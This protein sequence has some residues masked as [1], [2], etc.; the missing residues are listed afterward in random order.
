MGFGREAAL[1]FSGRLRTG[2]ILAPILL[3]GCTG[4]QSALSPAG[5]QAESLASLFWWMTFGTVVVWAGVIVLTVYAIRTEPDPIK[6]PRRAKLL[7]VVGGA[8]IPTIVLGVLLV[9]GLSLLPPMVAPAP[10]GSLRI[11]V[12]GEQWWWRVRYEHEGRSVELANEIRIPV[13]EPVQFELLSSNVIHAFWI[14]PLG[15]KRDMIPG[16]TTQLALTATR[17]GFFRGVCAEYCGASHALMSFVTEVMEKEAFTRWVE[18]QAQNSAEPPSDLASRGRDA[19]LQN[20]CGACHTIRGTTAA[21]VLGP[22]L[23]HVGGRYSLG[24]GIL[25]NN[26]AMLE[27][28]IAYPD[29]I[30]PSVH[31]PAFRMLPDEER[32]ALAAFLAGLK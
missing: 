3:V 23:T 25:T 19:F 13:D 6:D 14:P 20:G 26:A 12:I 10:E 4:S 28:W 17:T 8:V 16:R 21:G 31:M 7:I 1:R 18:A 29:R 24:A 9:Y 27:R 32:E 11:T 2:V 5:P 22:D 15:G 30:K